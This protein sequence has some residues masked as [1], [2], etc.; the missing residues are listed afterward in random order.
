MISLLGEKR[1]KRSKNV[2]TLSVFIIIVV[3]I[4]ISPVHTLYINKV[5]CLSKGKMKHGIRTSTIDRLEHLC[6]FFWIQGNFE[7]N[8]LYDVH[9]ERAKFVCPAY[10]LYYILEL[11]FIFGCTTMPHLFCPPYDRK[12]R[13]KLKRK[14]LIKSPRLVVVVGRRNRWIW[15]LSFRLN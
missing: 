8:N 9:L 2:K 12:H 10:S 7:M 5:N 6:F 4:T 3:I 14:F 13:G 1:S 11:V 15:Y